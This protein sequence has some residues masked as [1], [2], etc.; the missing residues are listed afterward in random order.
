MKWLNETTH[1]VRLYI[2]ITWVTWLLTA[3]AVV[4]VVPI[5]KGCWFIQHIPWNKQINNDYHDLLQTFNKTLRVILVSCK[6]MISASNESNTS[7]KFC[8]L[9]RMPFI[10]QVTIFSDIFL[11]D[12]VATPPWDYFLD[13]T[14]GLEYFF[15]IVFFFFII[16]IINRF[17][18]ITV[19][20]SE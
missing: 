2:I 17:C 19:N 1:T 20:V 4:R 8:W 18:L 10:F 6:A 13:L 5:D 15:L 16:I 11:K 9:E 3:E 12:I 14:I 7:F